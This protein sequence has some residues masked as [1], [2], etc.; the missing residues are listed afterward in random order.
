MKATRT[1][2]GAGG[3]AS[4]VCG[5]TLA[6]GLALGLGACFHAT[7]H[8]ERGE[9]FTTGQPSY[10][11]FFARVHELHE[12]AVRARERADLA[13]APLS[14]ALGIDGTAAPDVAV[15]AIQKRA[16]AL[17]TK[18][19]LLHLQ[20]TP[21]AKVV[22]SGATDE[23]V[24]DLVKA[25]EDAARASVDLSHELGGA[26]DQA[27][28]LQKTRADL[29]ARSRTELHAMPPVKR[30]EITRE[31]EAAKGVID[32][33]QQTIALYAGTASKFVLD[34]AH[35]IETGAVPTPAASS[36]PADDAPKPK[37]KPR[38]SPRPGPVAHPAGPSHT[39][40]PPPKKK[41]AGGD[42]FEP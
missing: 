21:E 13:R 36:T 8:V 9:T 14:H 7:T 30:E 39:P 20:L 35:A 42:D 2:K 10:D 5:A 24:R 38:W 16:N 26:A 29:D 3:L 34:V 37:P 4:R 15:T 23:S 40:P 25:I 1:S 32:D 11:E 22:T 17:K 19:V 33:D 31:L 12:R 28:E 41:P 27:A 18:H 6:F